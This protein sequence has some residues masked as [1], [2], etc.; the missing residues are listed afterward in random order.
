M[1]LADQ[2]AALRPNHGGTRCGVGSAL[3]RM[4]DADQA[5]LQAALD[6]PTLQAAGISQVLRNNGYDVGDQAVSRH[7]RGVCQCR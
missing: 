7:R 5:A 2:F 3:D 1:G 4:D 6:N